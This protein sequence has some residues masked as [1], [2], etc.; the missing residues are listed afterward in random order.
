MK[1]LILFTGSLLVLFSISACKTGPETP[2]P[3]AKEDGQ[4]QVNLIPE[5]SSDEY[6]INLENSLMELDIV[7]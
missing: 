4:E 1:K 2:P 6:D 3:D 7:E 5:E